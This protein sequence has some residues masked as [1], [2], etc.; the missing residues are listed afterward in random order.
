MISG[1]GRHMAVQVGGRGQHLDSAFVLRQNVL[2]KCVVQ[3]VDVLGD[4]APVEFRGYF[5]K[6]GDFPEEGIHV[7]KGH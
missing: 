7:Q 2:Q 6:Q 4:L 3:P 1:V 5:K